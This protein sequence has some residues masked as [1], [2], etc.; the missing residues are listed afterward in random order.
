[1]RKNSKPLGP[2]GAIW[3][4]YFGADVSYFPRFIGNDN[5]ALQIDSDDMIRR[6]ADEIGSPKPLDVSQIEN[7]IKRDR[8]S[9]DEV[10][11]PTE[12]G[13]NKATRNLT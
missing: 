3:R 6:I 7:L 12:Y 9:L 10:K 4:A 2:I 11:A 5:K 13:N 1:M 8:K